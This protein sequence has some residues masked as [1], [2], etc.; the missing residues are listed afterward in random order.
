MPAITGLVVGEG[1]GFSSM[2]NEFQFWSVE[3]RVLEVSL[4]TR[5][6]NGGRIKQREE[7]AKSPCFSA[8]LSLALP[9]P[10]TVK[11][12]LRAHWIMF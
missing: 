7:R 9:A 11:F 6:K 8:G 1:K 4:K 5:Q 10:S 3:V 12:L 2:D